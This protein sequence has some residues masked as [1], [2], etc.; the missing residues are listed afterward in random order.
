LPAPVELVSPS[1]SEGKAA[2]PQSIHSEK[3][4]MKNQKNQNKK[5]WKTT[6]SRSPSYS[7]TSQK[8]D[9]PIAS[10]AANWAIRTAEKV[11]KMRI[12]EETQ[13]CCY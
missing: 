6:L 9:P 8:H 2:K 5:R 11:R 1:T 10:I 12:V 4:K 3:M 13:Q 7:W